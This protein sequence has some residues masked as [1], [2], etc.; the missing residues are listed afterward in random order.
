METNN[1]KQDV[2]KYRLS[3]QELGDLAKLLKYSKEELLITKV[4]PYR[5][6][7]DYDYSKING[8]VGTILNFLEELN[9]REELVPYMS[10]TVQN[11]YKTI[12]NVNINVEGCHS[13]EEKLEYVIENSQYYSSIYWDYS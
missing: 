12:Y 2:I 1:L 4:L 13:L 10:K 8:K 6:E 11:L 9:K 3:E 7:I 5:K